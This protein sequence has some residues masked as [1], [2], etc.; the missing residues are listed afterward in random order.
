MLSLA[1]QSMCWRRPAD[2]V[3]TAMLAVCLAVAVGGCD[4][5]L[6]RKNADMVFRCETVVQDTPTGRVVKYKPIEVI[7]GDVGGEMLDGDRFLRYT[8]RLEEDEGIGDIYIFRL[9][10][11]DKDHFMQS[12]QHPFGISCEWSVEL[13]LTDGTAIT[14]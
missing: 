1:E 10:N 13:E 4:S 14:E 7:K 2:A 5:G 11:P 3:L 6:L 12:E 8:R 9:W